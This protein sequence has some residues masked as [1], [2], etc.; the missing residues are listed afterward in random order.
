[1]RATSCGVSAPRECTTLKSKFRVVALVAVTL[2]GA[3]CRQD[4]HDAPRYEA[5]EASASFADNRASRVP[6]AGTVA[7]GWL[8]D[9]EAL[10]TGKVAGQIV[11]QFPFAITAADMQRGQQRFNIYCTPCH[12][13]IGD[14]NG[15]VVQRGLRQAASFHQDRL[16]QEKAGYFFDVITNGFGAMQGYAEQIPV[17]DRWLIVAYVRALQLSQ[18]AS[19]DDVPADRR[20]ALDAAPSTDRR[21][22]AGCSCTG[23]RHDKAGG[24]T[25]MATATTETYQ[26][27]DAL[28]PGMKQFGMIATVL[29]VV[30]TLAGFLMS[31]LDRFYQAYLVAWVFWMGVVLGSLALLMTQ[32][33]SGGAWGVVLRRPLEAAVRTLPYMAVLF[34]PIYFGMHTLFEWTHPEVAQNDPVVSLKVAY[35]NTPFFLARQVIYFAIWITIATLLS[36]W[37]NEHDRTGDPALVSK[38]SKLSGAGL[39]IYFVTVTFAMVDWTMSVNPHWFS[40]IWGLLAIGGQGL[41]AMAFGIVVMIMLMQTPPLDRVVTKHHLHDLAKFL[42]AFLMLWAYLSF[43][44]FLIIWSANLPEEIPHYLTRWANGWQIVSV[45]V[46]VGHFMIPYALL[47]SRDLKRNAGK[48]RIIATWV[49]CARL[50]DYYWH[51]APEFDTHKDGWNPSLLDVALPLALGGIFI[52]IFVSQ[53]RG[54]SLLPVNDPGLEKALHHHVH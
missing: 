51:V 15:M 33:L 46:V 2:T 50:A 5:F 8:R 38:M 25:L 52:S 26:A 30:L 3:A 29:G 18:H 19:V 20:V 1:M 7:R 54:R 31:G 22:G 14:G 36:K 17:R 39:V 45:F 21:R 16:R 24:K 41:S 43:S 32:H 9:D 35:L 49:V 47:L 40:T 44:Q 27:P 48:L 23:S 12:S 4:M 37:S 11:D 6:P 28:L 53:L 13:R 42:F 34:L 10:Y